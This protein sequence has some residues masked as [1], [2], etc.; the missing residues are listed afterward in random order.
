MNNQYCLTGLPW[1]IK[2]EAK[3]LE[4]TRTFYYATVLNHHP[5]KDTLE[6]FHYPL[7]VAG[8]LSWVIVYFCIWKG[9]QS[10]GKIAMF[11]VLAPYALLSVLFIRVTFLDGFGMGLAF[12]FKPDFKKLLTFEIWKDALIQITFQYSI[13]QAILP[14]FASFRS[15]NQKIALPSKL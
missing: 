14:T 7:L 1:D 8:I 5:N 2:D 10:T 13:G 3:I 15:V 6:S 11:T 12:L 9:V 4:Q